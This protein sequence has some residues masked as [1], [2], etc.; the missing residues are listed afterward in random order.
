MARA[1]LLLLIVGVLELLTLRFYLRGTGIPPW[2]FLGSYNND[3][4]L[5]WSNG[6]FFHP[7]DWIPNV[8]AG[9]PSALNLQ[10][11]SWY[12]PVGAASA[13]GAFT[14]KS[15]AI[16]QALHVAFGFFGTYF[17]VRSFGQRFAVAAFASTAGFFAVGYFSNAEHVD[18][19]RGYA[20]IPWVLLVLSPHWPWKRVWAIPLGA[21]IL[22]QA[23]TGIYPG[24]VVSTVYVGVVWIAVG[25]I[26]AKVRAGEYLLPLG[27][28]ILIGGLLSLPRWLPYF[29]LSE[30]AT[31]GLAETSR[32]SWGMVGTL[33][34]GYSSDGLPND[35]SMRS[36]FV[37]AAVLVLIFFVRWRHPLVLP[38][39]AIG[40]PAVL[41]GAPFLPWFQASQSLPGLGLSRFT[42]SDFK[43]FFVLAAV[44]LGSAGL[45][46]LL[47]APR[48]AKRRTALRLGG[49]VVFVAIMAAVGAFGPFEQR[50]WVPET[51]ILVVV[52]VAA[53]AFALVGRR[54]RLVRAAFP[55]VILLLTVMSGVVW[56]H[57]TAAP[58]LDARVGAEIV[59]Y[60][61]TV[62]DLLANRVVDSLLE[63]RPARLGPGEGY[64]L[65]TLL[66][67]EWNRVYYTGEY[68]VGGYLNLKGS[69][70]ELELQD[71]LLDE[72]SGA[73]FASFLEAP[74]SIL[75]TT[76]GSEVD[77]E[78]LRDCGERGLCGPATVRPVSYSPGRYEYQVSTGS[79]VSALFNEA[80]FQGW[81]ATACFA[82][83]ECVG[84]E[85]SRSSW[86]LVGADLPSGEYTLDLDYVT[87]GRTAGWIAF[88]FGIALA[89]ALTG[90]AIVRNRARA[91]LAQ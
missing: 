32:F 57:T 6:S 91:R 61:D 23:V 28:T 13:F 15:A 83:G 4:F 76:S 48:E 37:P 16:V 1:A 52:A 89:L 34:F 22:W 38:G 8:W 85:V 86:G 62:D 51:I 90:G 74:G 54:G 2:D 81:Q 73:D 58:W 26:T 45:S 69:R 66:S 24:M 65:H 43:V 59:T 84:I 44:L 55:L 29:L 40:I 75:T 25:Q 82:A 47:E 79:A 18:I 27:A 42:M 46:A 19:V 80:Y 63:Q 7:P 56:T 88:G 39:L 12:L 49:I 31:G 41:L 11:S 33:L 72:A 17:L 35:I 60:G 68:A 64:D 36:L 50:D 53:A 3:A 30:D 67:V 5:W 10:N 70:T 9:Y 78:R 21:L 87:P 20:W 14:L 77:G 71:A